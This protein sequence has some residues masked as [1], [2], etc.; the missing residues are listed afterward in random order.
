MLSA[1]VNIPLDNFTFWLQN[2]N[3]VNKITIHLLQVNL[4]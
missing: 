2:A 3:Q 1:K 4:I